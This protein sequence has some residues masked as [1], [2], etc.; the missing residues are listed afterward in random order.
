MSIASATGKTS[1]VIV[2][3]D[4]LDHA[5]KRGKT[6]HVSQSGASMSRCLYVYVDVHPEGATLSAERRQ[7]LPPL[8]LLVPLPW[9]TKLLFSKPIL[10]FVFTTTYSGLFLPRLFF[11]DSFISFFK[12]NFTLTF[13]IRCYGNGL[14]YK[15]SACLAES[16]KQ[17]TLVHVKVSFSFHSSPP[18]TIKGRSHGPLQGKLL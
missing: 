11:C 2:S 13:C 8:F 1:F 14:V 7:T 9:I 6:S 10:Y 15:T 18:L 3:L 5:Y 12:Y 17:E 16:S 4:D